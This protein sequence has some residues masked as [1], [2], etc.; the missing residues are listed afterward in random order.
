MVLQTTGAFDLNKGYDLSKVGYDTNGNILTLEREGDPSVSTPMDDLLYTYDT[1]SNQ[2][3]TV[4]DNVS[5]TQNGFI[6][7][8]NSNGATDYQYDANGNMIQDLHKDITDID[9]NHLN[10]PI[11]VE[12]ENSDNNTIKYIYDATGVKQ[13]KIVTENRTNIT[14]TTYAGNYIYEGHR[15]WRCIEVLLP[16]RGLC[17]A[18]WQWWLQ[19]C[20]PV[21]GPLGQREID[22]YPGQGQLGDHR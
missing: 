7:G 2:L 16:S 1:N 15:L 17:G 21:Q 18:R 20:L 13:K 14:R 4:K 11:Y 8:P 19:L 12:F 3:F 22:L 5:S 6:S 10:L 9:Y